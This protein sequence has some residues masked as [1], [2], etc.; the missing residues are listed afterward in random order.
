[1]FVFG[2]YVYEFYS[3][4][5]TSVFTITTAAVKEIDK[6]LQNALLVIEEQ[7]KKIQKL[8]DEMD[9]LK[10]MVKSLMK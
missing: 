10:A 9:E 5:Y 6:E 8:T 3:V 2:Q 4:N 7:K 1:L